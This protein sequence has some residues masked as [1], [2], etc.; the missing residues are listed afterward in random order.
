MVVELVLSLGG[1]YITPGLSF[2]SFALS[3][4]QR[5]HHRYNGRVCSV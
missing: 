4:S 2:A 5:T 1:D 3:D